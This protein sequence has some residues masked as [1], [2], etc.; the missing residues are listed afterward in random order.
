MTWASQFFPLHHEAYWSE[1]ELKLILDHN[2]KHSKKGH[3]RSTRLRNKMD[4]KEGCTSIH[5]GICKTQG[6]D[7]RKYQSRPQKVSIE[8]TPLSSCVFHSSYLLT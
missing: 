2:L 3:P 6:N 5:C 7:R 4:I 1:P 8:A